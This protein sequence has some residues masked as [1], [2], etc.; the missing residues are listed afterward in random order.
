MACVKLPVYS[1]FGEEDVCM[2]KGGTRPRTVNERGAATKQA[3]QRMGD[4]SLTAD[5]LMEA[6]VRELRRSGKATLRSF[7]TFTI[8]EAKPRAAGSDKVKLGKVV[9]FRASPT[10]TK[11]IEAPD[12]VLGDTLAAGFAEAV[13]LAIGQAHAAGLS[14]PGRENR[15]PVERRPDGRITTIDDDT[16]WSPERWNSRS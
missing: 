5:G 2:A 13:D 15:T 10:L 6:L 12:A 14:V 1:G 4:A 7:G 3:A 16:D 11:A 9:R 8:S